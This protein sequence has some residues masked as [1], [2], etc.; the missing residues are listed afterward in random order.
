MRFE[1]YEPRATLLLMKTGRI[2]EVLRCNTSQAFC[3]YVDHAGVPAQPLP[4]NEC[5]FS[6][7]F[8]GSYSRPWVLA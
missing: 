6:L 1:R 2:I 8:L 7:E 3:R 5:T 4:R